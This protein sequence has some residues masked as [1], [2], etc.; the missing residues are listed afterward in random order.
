[1]S[2]PV[3]TFGCTACDLKARDTQTWGYR[4]Y[5]AEG[6]ELQMRVAMGWCES[7]SDLSAIEIK[8]TASLDAQLV[9]ETERLRAEIAEQGVSN[10]LIR[11]WWQRK[12][13]KS[14][15]LSCAESE[16]SGA[17]KQL[18]WLRQLRGLME[19]RQS[20]NRCLRC[21]AEQCLQLPAL[22]LAASFD[23]CHP[24]PVPIGFSH[25]GCGGELTVCSD[26]LRLS[27][28]PVAKAYDLE[29]RRLPAESEKRR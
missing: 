2:M 29:G 26:A 4:F 20:G 27:I 18:A 28:Q 22:P 23:G 3:L 12:A 14:S 15:A 10:P 6:K 9:A 24:D 21:E 16:L 17:Q 13:S 8:P 1:M 19:N 11:R 25:P 7:C 5:Q